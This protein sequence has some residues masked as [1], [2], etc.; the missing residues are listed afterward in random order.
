MSIGG[1]IFGRAGKAAHPMAAALATCRSAFI[2]LAIFSGIIN[3]L[4]LTG[5][6]YML[7]VYDRVLLSYSVPTLIMLSVIAL[8]AFA[9]QGF[10]ETIRTRI[11]GRIGE[12]VD[13]VTGPA[14]Y[15]LTIRQQVSRSQ[16]Q[17]EY[18]QPF[19]DLESVRQFLVGSGPVAFFD[20]PWLPIYIIICFFLHPLV[21]WFCLLSAILLLVVAIFSERSTNRPLLQAYEAQS[22]RNMLAEASIRGAEAVLSMGML[23]ALRRRWADLHDRYSAVTLR[24]SDTASG[25]ASWSRTLRMVIQSAI[26]GLGAYLVIRGEMTAGT[27]IAASILSARAIAPVDMAVASF[28]QFQQA[29]IGYGRLVRLF[30]ATPDKPDMLRLP[31]PRT[32]LAVDNVYIVPPNDQRPIIK[33]ISFQLNAGQGL[34]I[35]GPSA[36]GKSTLGRAIVG[37]WPPARGQVALDQASLQHWDSEL[38]GEHIGY[39]PHDVQLFD[40]TIAENIARFQPDAPPEKILKAARLAGFHE[41]ILAMPD[42]FNTRIGQGGAHLSAGQ[43]QRVG[44]ARALY[45]DPFLVVLDE[46]NAN[47]DAEG[48]A[49]VTN[50]LMSVRGRGGIAVVIAHRPSAIAAVDMLL[51]VKGGVAVAFGRKDEVLKKVVSNA[52]A[53]EPNALPGAP[54]G[55]GPRVEGP[56]NETSSNAGKQ[57]GGVS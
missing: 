32:N 29:R 21:G 15:D 10:L 55:D 46:P 42:G 6:F 37:L 20:L 22:H 27:I 45:G 40:G 50:A 16:A 54:R 4:M 18:M 51:V 14:L 11:F 8:T 17:G 43:R 33:G 1:T 52:S 13:L 44:I 49:A 19:R 47:L 56:R 25:L 28:K 38:L 31:A 30:T 34:G 36:S 35:I 57:V 7:Q 53:I 9:F 3:V 12:R 5:S 41:D 39:M 48:E 24:A 23:A 2:A 26:L